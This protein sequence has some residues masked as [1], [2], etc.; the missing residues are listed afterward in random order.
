MNRMDRSSTKHNVQQQND[1][2]DD[3]VNN[4]EIRKEQVYLDSNYSFGC[5]RSHEP[6]PADI[7]LMAAKRRMAKKLES[8]E[9]ASALLEK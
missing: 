2:S 5:S 7:Y 6:P 3:S 9:F 1:G 8:S 4:L